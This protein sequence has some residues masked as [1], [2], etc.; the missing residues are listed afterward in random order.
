MPGN[1]LVPTFCDDTRKSLLPQA[2]E[3][4]YAGVRSPVVSCAAGISG[5]RFTNSNPSW[6]LCVVTLAKGERRKAGGIRA[7]HLWAMLTLSKAAWRFAS[8]CS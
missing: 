5:I 6:S 2:G 3:C 8:K 7:F 1:T 4:V